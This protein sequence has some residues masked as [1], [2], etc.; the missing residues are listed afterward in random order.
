MP[1]ELEYIDDGAG[2]LWTGKGVVT[3]REL[4]AA[5][6]EIY[7]DQHVYAQR[8]QIVDLTNAER[9][10][11]SADDVRELAV[12]DREGAAKNPNIVVAIAGESDLV[13][14]LARLWE[15]HVHKSPLQTRVF[16]TVDE[17]RQW[18]D[19]ALNEAE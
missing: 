15:A 11:V 7:S 18:V 13:F 5:N 14:G 19:T 10:D 16:R 2:V 17:A 4:Y 1:V 9:F 6:A 3:G 12:Q 8:Y